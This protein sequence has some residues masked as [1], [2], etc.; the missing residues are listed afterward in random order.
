MRISTNTIF[1]AGASAISRQQ[2]DLL[3]T[4]QQISANRRV[5][6][7]SDDPIASARA[8]EV[9]Q[10]DSINTQYGTNAKTAAGRLSLTEQA[11][12][13]V[14]DLL[15][16]VRQ[17]AVRGGDGS[18]APTDRKALALDV[19]SMY[20][21]L[22]EVANTDD[23]EGNYLFS[24]FQTD[25]KPFTAT[26]ASVQY[27]GDD[28]E[29]LVQISSSR[30]IPISESGA[31]SFMRIRQGN[32]SFVVSAAAAN[33]GTA[34]YS[35]G[36]VT[37][38]V[39][40]TR[41]QYSV[42]FT[43]TGAA[44]NTTTTYDVIDNT[45]GSTLLTAQPYTAG[46]AIGFDGMQLEVAGDPAN[47]D[48]IQVAPSVDQDLFKT[49]SDLANLLENATHTPAGRTALANGLTSTLANLDQSLEKVAVRRS[50]VGTRMREADSLQSNSEDLSLQYQQTLSQLQDLDYAKTVSDLMQQQINLEAAQKSFVQTAKLSIFN[51]L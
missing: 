5:L 45:T 46:A 38:P 12:G 16:S 43:V 37:N 8:L 4:Q 3:K 19:R 49:V 31:E 32:G 17:S 25:V 36:T 22:M 27:Q 1:D 30:Q 6:T 24:G 33:T 14:V 39:L 42:A 20:S 51:Y 35:V 9:G 11:L 21:A 18:L 26:A 13:R 23:G 7:P 10:A 15:Q 41:D 48:M 50:L 44:P 2:S 40:L 34:T 47:G 28:G 29:R